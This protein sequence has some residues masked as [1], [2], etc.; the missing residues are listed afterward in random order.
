MGFLT[1]LIIGEAPAWINDCHHF[2]LFNLACIL[3]LLEH[4]FLPIDSLRDWLCRFNRFCFLHQ[5]IRLDVFILHVHSCQEEVVVCIV[6]DLDPCLI[7]TILES[8]LSFLAQFSLLFSNSR[9]FLA[10]PA[11]GLITGI[12]WVMWW[13][14]EGL[15]P[16]AVYDA[17][18]VHLDVIRFSCSGGTTCW[19]VANWRWWTM[20]LPCLSTHRLRGLNAP[21]RAWICVHSARYRP[22]VSIW[23]SICVCLLSDVLSHLGHARA[24]RL[25]TVQLLCTCV[26]HLYLL[27]S[28]SLLILI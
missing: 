16:F 13:L 2:I 8:T 6:S 11:T 14:H 21:N 22:N 20:A 9:A 18:L 27:I 23:H 15:L 3:W 19:G 25:S 26:T 24:C 28:H 7:W 10:R 12:V 4:K 17:K 1:Y 5:G